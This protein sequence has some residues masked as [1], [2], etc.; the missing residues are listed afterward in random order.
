MHEYVAWAVCL[1]TV[2][3]IH[4]LTPSCMHHM[5]S[6]VY[7]YILGELL[8]CQ[9]VSRMPPIVFEFAA[10]SVWH[11]HPRVSRDACSTL[12]GTRACTSI[13]KSTTTATTKAAIVVGKWPQHGPLHHWSKA[14]LCGHSCSKRWLVCW[15]GSLL[16]ISIGFCKHAGSLTCVTDK[17]YQT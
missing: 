10:S 15:A 7:A 16:H 11:I 6:I 9:S 2:P 13:I 8:L 14:R 5:R 3:T 12:T 17:A 4:M 1:H